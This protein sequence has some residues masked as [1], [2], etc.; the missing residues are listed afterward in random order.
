MFFFITLIQSNDVP[1]G[2]LRKGFDFSFNVYASPNRGGV[3]KNNDK[4]CS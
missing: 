1:S 2:P 4:S 3:V